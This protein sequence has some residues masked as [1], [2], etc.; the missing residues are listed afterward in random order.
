MSITVSQ[1]IEALQQ[2][3]KDLP[4]QVEYIGVV[5]SD[6]YLLQILVNDKTKEPIISVENG[7]CVI[8]TA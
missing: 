2:I 7:K 3:D 4:V 8:T 1:L 5:P 6:D